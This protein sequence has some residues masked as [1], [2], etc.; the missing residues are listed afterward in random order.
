[1]L[2]VTAPGVLGYLTISTRFTLPL[3]RHTGSLG[4]KASQPH[5]ASPRPGANAPQPHDPSLHSDAEPRSLPFLTIPRHSSPASPPTRDQHPH[6]TTSQPAIP[7]QDLHTIAFHWQ[8]PP[9]LLLPPQYLHPSAAAPAPYPESAQKYGAKSASA[10][11]T[12]SNESCNRTLMDF[13]A[14][15]SNRSI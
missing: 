10:G 13:L 6:I 4:A 1:M 7:H 14:K 3:W 9:F 5:D 12:R 2:Y 8:Y 15:R 11:R